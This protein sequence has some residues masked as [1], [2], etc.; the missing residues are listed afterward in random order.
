MHLR[1][2][3]SF[4]RY[5]R[6]RNGIG[7]CWQIGHERWA[8]ISEFFPTVS[9]NDYVIMPNHMHGILFLAE[10][11]DKRPSIGNIINHYKGSV[12]RIARQELEFKDK[13]W[14][15]RYHD[16]IIRNEPDLIRIKEYVQLNP[17]RWEADT[18]YD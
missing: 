10:S 9:L 14:Q 1:E 18:F 12:T 7:G 4:W 15:A 13:I 6:W 11:H 3:T 2:S 17:A 5:Q 8:M 16:H